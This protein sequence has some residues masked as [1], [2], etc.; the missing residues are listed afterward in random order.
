M[1]ECLAFN[2]SNMKKAILTLAVLCGIGLM[3]GCKNKV[4]SYDVDTTEPTCTFV[5]SPRTYLFDSLQYNEEGFAFI[6][7]LP[8][9]CTRIKRYRIEKGNPISASEM[10]VDAICFDYCGEEYFL[11]YS[12]DWSEKFPCSA[13][14][15]IKV[16]RDYKDGGDPFAIITSYQID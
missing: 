14:L 7:G 8:V 12:M 2:F 6:N 10:I 9:E 15:D 16:W 4:V 5:P 3:A 1:I 13:K 11:P